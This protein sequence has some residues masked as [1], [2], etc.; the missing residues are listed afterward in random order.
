MN[1]CPYPLHKIASDGLLT[2][3][4]ELRC[5]RVSVPE[6]VLNAL[7]E[8]RWYAGCLQAPLKHPKDVVARDA[9]VRQLLIA[10]ARRA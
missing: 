3:I 9:T 6:E 5:P 2:R 1:S 4:V 10:T 8:R 7:N